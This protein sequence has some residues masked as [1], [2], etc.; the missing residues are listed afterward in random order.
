M[1]KSPQVNLPWALIA[2]GVPRDQVYDTLTTP[3]GVDRAFRKL[4]TIKDEVLW[5]EAGAQPPQMLADGE[6]AMTSAYN[7]RLYNAI[8]KEGQPFE[9]VWD[10]QIWDYAAFVIPRARPTRIRPSSSSSTR[11]RPN[12]WRISPTISPTARPAARAMQWCPMN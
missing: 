6:V 8:V 2:D 7:G 3:E 9:I 1:R 12:G 10:S 11:L 4:D 5:W